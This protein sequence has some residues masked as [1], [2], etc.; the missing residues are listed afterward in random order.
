MQQSPSS[1][2]LPR[3]LDNLLCATHDPSCCAILLR[4]LRFDYY[5]ASLISLSPVLLRMAR[6]AM[7]L[8]PH[9]DIPQH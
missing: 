1:F 8:L 9:R 2:V 6:T 7:T 4:G 5:F 3:H